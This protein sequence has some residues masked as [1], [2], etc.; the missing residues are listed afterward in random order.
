MHGLGDTAFGWADVMHILATRLPHLKFILPTAP[1]QPVS[2]NQ[3]R[4][5]PLPPAGAACVPHPPPCSLARLRV[6]GAVMPSWYNIEGLDERANEG[7]DGIDDS[8][9][10]IA[11]F[12]DKEVRAGTPASRIVLGGFSQ[13]GAL[14]IYSALCTR[15]VA[16]V[17]VLS[18]Y[19]P[20]ARAVKPQKASLA[21]KV[22]V[23]Q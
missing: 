11:T 19:L 6:Q 7:C 1:S 20:R 4:P 5:R 18:G 23:C 9:A 17:A 16:G 8:C 3:V 14:A 10:T 2:I 22:L 21:A 15:S 12:I 13:G